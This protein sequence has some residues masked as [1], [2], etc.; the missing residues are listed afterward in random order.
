MALGAITAN[1]QTLSLST[2]AGTDITK[3]D[4]QTKTVSV[5]RYMFNGWNTISLPFAMSAQQLDEVFGTDCKLEKLAG[6]EEDDAQIKLNFQDCKEEGI[7]ANVPYILYYTGESGT[8]KILIENASLKK[9]KASVSFKNV[10]GIEVVF[11]CAQVKTEAKGLYGVLAKDNS[12]ASFVNVDNIENG[13]Y[14]TRCYV[15]LSNGNTTLLSTNHINSG[16]TTSIQSVLKSN[17]KAD[18]YSVSGSKIASG[19][20]ASAVAKLPAGIYVVKGKKIAV[21]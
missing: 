4:G 20:N 15:Q 11:A 6:V 3:Y 19:L 5:S 7:K 8:K 18:V 9:G 17:E 10:N 2:Y 16:E 21:R 14:A 1:A 13:F 12:E